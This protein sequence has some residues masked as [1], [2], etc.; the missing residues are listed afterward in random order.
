MNVA[1]SYK[2][3][4]FKHFVNCCLVKNYDKNSIANNKVTVLKS[5]V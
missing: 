4:V 3:D 1:D 5:R 2:F